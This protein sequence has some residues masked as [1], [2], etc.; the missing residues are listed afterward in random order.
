MVQQSRYIAIMRLLKTE[1]GFTLI[2]LSIVVAVIGLIVGGIMVG[3]SLMRSAEVQSVVYDVD[4]YKKAVE[5]FKEK[6]SYLPGDMPTATSFW[7]ADANCPATPPNIIP[8]KATCNGNG[9]G[10]IGSKVGDPVGGGDIPDLYETLRAWQQLA[11]AGF[12]DSSYSG[13]VLNALP[14]LVLN[15]GINIP[16]S[17]IPGNGFIFN[18]SSTAQSNTVTFPANYGHV[19]IYGASTVPNRFAPV[20]PGLTTAEAMSIDQKMD[21][22]L[23]GSGNVLSPNPTFPPVPNCATTNVV[24]TAKYNIGYTTGPACSLIFITGF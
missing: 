18:Y 22:G 24:S 7:G 19:I 10:F 15:V 12:I 6:Y 2:E 23:P 16:A 5:Q 11:D 3:Q 14:S 13:A 1:C 17:K 8:K 4:R 20:G 9:D 21:D